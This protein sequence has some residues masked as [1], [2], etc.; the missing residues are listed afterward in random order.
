M[1]LRGLIAIAK[2]DATICQNVT[3]ARV[4]KGQH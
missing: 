2:D 1:D 4:N 3:R